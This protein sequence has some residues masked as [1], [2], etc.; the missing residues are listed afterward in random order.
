MSIIDKWLNA[1]RDEKS[2]LATIDICDN[3][4]S[5]LSNNDLDVAKPLRQPCDISA[6][7]TADEKCRNAV[8]GDFDKVMHQDQMCNSDVAVVADVAE[9]EIR[10]NIAT[11][12][13]SSELAENPSSRLAVRQSEPAAATVPEP[14][15]FRGD[16]F[17]WRIRA[18]AATGV[19]PQVLMV[20]ARNHG[21]KLTRDGGTLSV[22]APYPLQPELL[23][24]LATHSAPILAR[25]SRESDERIAQFRRNGS[26]PIK[27]VLVFDPATETEFSQ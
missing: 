16:E 19:N 6:P 2:S 15:R 8:A 25:L 9:G 24:A 26:G 17:Q 10:E 13:E 21:A 23:E 5:P 27:E 20:R 11:S 7:E 4:K 1:H 14:R 3:S 12:T 18:G 22:T